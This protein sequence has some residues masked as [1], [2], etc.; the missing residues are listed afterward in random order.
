MDEEQGI[1]AKPL[2]RDPNQPQ[3][4]IKF[5]ITASEDI[6]SIGE[7]A[8]Y[9]LVRRLINGT[10]VDVDSAD[11]TVIVS[12]ASD[13]GASVT[14]R[15]KGLAPTDERNTAGFVLAR[16]DDVASLT[17]RTGNVPTS[18]GTAE[19]ATGAALNPSLIA[20]RD[21]TPPKMRLRA[22]P[23]FKSGS[24]FNGSFEVNSTETVDGIESASS[25]VLLR[26]SDP[27]SSPP[28]E[29]NM[30]NCSSTIT[31]G[32]CVL[33][34]TITV[35][36]T[37]VA[38]SAAT[39]EYRVVDAMAQSG[40]A[41][42]L[43]RAERLTDLSGNLPVDPSSATNI[44][45]LANQRLDTGTSALVA[46]P[47]LSNDPSLSELTLKWFDMQESRIVTINL[48]ESEK[49]EYEQNFR[50]EVS[51]TTLTATVTVGSG[52]TIANTTI[53]RVT[54]SEDTEQRTVLQADTPEQQ[55][56]AQSITFT[57]EGGTTTIIEIKVVAENGSTAETYT[58]SIRHARSGIYIRA[59]VFLEGPLE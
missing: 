33:S 5:R 52:A 39:V 28:I 36:D 45:L 9:K 11:R 8:S 40:Q 49:T 12:N 2:G 25:Y 51:S 15:V 55:S 58:V 16:G 56:V 30:S 48:L 46:I 27:N 32:A 54:M 21:T 38:G 31:D 37:N 3:Y 7:A 42:T 23:I 29:I 35:T 10:S 53:T 13:R 24:N 41:F 47:D 19:I 57:S 1:G 14:Y 50:N 34:A 26:V 18:D 17:D 20:D 59:R 44:V 4:E 43:G 6:P 22:S